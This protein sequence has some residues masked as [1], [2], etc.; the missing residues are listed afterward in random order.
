V[1]RI[2]VFGGYGTFGS[3]VA[4]GLAGRGHALVIAGRDG[5]R[6]RRFAA[7]LGAGHEGR[8]ADAGDPRSCAEALRGQ[9]VAVACAGPFRHLGD[10][11]LE[12]SL[13]EG[14]HYADIAD[15]RAYAARVRAAGP[16]F[17]A[18]GLCAAYGC[19]SLPGLSGALALRAAEGAPAPPRAARVTLF[20]GNDNPK[21]GAA[22]ES[23]LSILGK[24]IPVPQGT[25]TGFGE[26][27]GVPL[28]PPFGM[29]RAYT[30]EA[31]DYDLLPGLLGVASVS[32]KVA[33]ER[34]L[35]NRLF[36]LL[37][38][39]R[40]PLGRR[41]ARLLTAASRLAGR[42]GTSGGAVMVELTLA[43]GLRRSAALVA[44]RDGQRMA[45]LPCVI[46]ADALASSG[47]PPGSH[48][49]YAVVPAGA[50]LEQTAREGFRLVQ[51]DGECGTRGHR[52]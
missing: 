21:G 22:V 48:P 25:L 15:D 17:G 23:L 52:S 29:R 38:R 40:R 4:R 2:T 3:L 1:A 34:G 12:A 28:P 44:D 5:E 16:R 31:P 6:A 41:A 14:C 49:G 50:L 37:A 27:E 10:A 46:A 11:L 33:F 36:A 35:A 51:S 19:S 24:R 26:P 8:A 13:R 30:F 43:G 18:A 9:A 20:I 32:V 42:G 39:L 47:G 7:A 45:A